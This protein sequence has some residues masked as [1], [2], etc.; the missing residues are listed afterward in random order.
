M[1][2]ITG[3]G[4]QLSGMMT[5][6]LVA[7]PDE[8]LKPLLPLLNAMGFCL[9]GEIGWSHMKPEDGNPLPEPHHRR[10]L[11]HGRRETLE[12]GAKYEVR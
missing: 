3:T 2:S 8:P 1:G 9:A 5:A 6:Y 4:C 10:H 11:P 7:N 12:K